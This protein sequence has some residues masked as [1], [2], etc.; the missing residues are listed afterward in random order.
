VSQKD[1]GERDQLKGLP[2]SHGMGQ[3]AAKPVG[4]VEPGGR[5]DDVVEEE[6][7]ASNL[8]NNEIFLPLHYCLFEI[9]L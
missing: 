2:E 1:I 3:D 5:L 8:I 9:A 7:D 4:R 6:S